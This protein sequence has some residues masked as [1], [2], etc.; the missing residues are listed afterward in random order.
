MDVNLLGEN[1]V[2]VVLAIGAPIFALLWLASELNKW[3][4]QNPDPP[5]EVFEGE[6]EH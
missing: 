5:P 6:S 3:Y 2:T 1:I 4:E